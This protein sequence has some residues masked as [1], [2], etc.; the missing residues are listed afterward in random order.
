M[1][2]ESAITTGAEARMPGEIRIDGRRVAFHGP[3]TDGRRVVVFFH[4]APGSGLFGLATGSDFA[5]V[6]VDR[7]GYG[8]SDPVG[9]GHWA[10]VASAAD[11]AA[12]VVRA[13]GVTQATTVGWSAG[14]RVA[15]ALAARHP[16]VVE[17][18]VVVATP[19]PHEEVPWIPPPQY[20]S[21]RSMRGERAD[22]VHARLAA[23][24]QAMAPADP[25]SDEALALLARSPADDDALNDVL[26]RARLG[27]MLAAAFRQG[28]AGLAND[29]A[30]FTLQPWGFEWDAVR[31]PTLLV[32]GESDPLAGRRHG[33]WW[34]HA[35]SNAEL[36][37]VTGVGH[38]G[39][40]KG[41]EAA[42]RA[43]DRRS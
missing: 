7:P 18:V 14:G 29:I 1:R 24:L 21:L 19:A 4:P 16:E 39:V 37:T 38:I 28:V 5:V 20:E 41:W 15:L 31:A 3:R 6:G 43:V 36:M 32:Y 26:L 17:A 27:E 33:E 2:S 10:T 35:L 8:S 23:Q 13:L 34:Q 40:I 42:V 11:D 22:V 12:A 9:D 25:R 30:G